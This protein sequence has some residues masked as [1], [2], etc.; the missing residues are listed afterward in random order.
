LPET[1]GCTLRERSQAYGM[2]WFGRFFLP[3]LFRSLVLFFHKNTYI[4]FLI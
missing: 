4:C 1:P 3:Q 2:Q